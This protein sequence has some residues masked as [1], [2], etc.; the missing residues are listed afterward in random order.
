M[1]TFFPGKGGAVS[2][3][4]YSKA[5]GGSTKGL[6]EHLKRI[7]GTNAMKRKNPEIATVMADATIDT[8]CFCVLII[9]L[10][11]DWTQW[12]ETGYWIGLLY[13]CLS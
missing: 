13:C 3:V 9:S 12:T 2:K 4:H 10:R 1:G 6:H 7:H 11:I 5:T 8:L